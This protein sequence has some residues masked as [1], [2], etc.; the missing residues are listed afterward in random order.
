MKSL[1]QIQNPKA[2]YSLSN[3]WPTSWTRRLNPNRYTLDNFAPAFVVF[4]YNNKPFGFRL[5]FE[6]RVLAFVFEVWRS[7][8]QGVG[9]YEAPDRK[10]YML[11]CPVGRKGVGSGV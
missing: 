5:Q 4:A 2:L 8:L 6:L 3:I 9:F 11:K 10:A 1:L 7:G